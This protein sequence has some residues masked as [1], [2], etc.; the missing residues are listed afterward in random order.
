MIIKSKG[1]TN[2]DPTIIPAKA[3]IRISDH[4]V[5]TSFKALKMQKQAAKNEDQK[6]QEERDE[7]LLD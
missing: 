7:G 5:G 4:G 1:L 6:K 2:F 3:Q